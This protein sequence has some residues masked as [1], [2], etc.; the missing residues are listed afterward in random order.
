MNDYEYND[1]MEDYLATVEPNFEIDPFAN[2][3]VDLIYAQGEMI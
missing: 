1:Q 2:W 3:E